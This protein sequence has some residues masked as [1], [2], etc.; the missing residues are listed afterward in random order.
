MWLNRD[1]PTALSANEKVGV[2]RQ[3][4]ELNP[5][6]AV[7]FTGGEPFSKFAEL[8][9]LAATA[10]ALGLVS[11]VNTNGSLIDRYK[12]AAVAADGP[13]HTVVSLDSIQPDLHDR[14]RGVEGAFERATQAITLLAQAFRGRPE[15]RIFVSS[16]LFEGNLA[17]VPALIALA[18]FL[19]AHGITFQLLDHTFDRRGK[20]DKFFE[21]GWFKDTR[22]A[23]RCLVDYASRIGPDAFVLTQSEGLIAMAARVH[24]SGSGTRPVC[25]AHRRNLVVNSSGDVLLCAYMRQLNEGRSLGNVRLQRLA[26]M[27]SGEEATR[28]RP[29]MASCLKPCGLLNCNRAQETP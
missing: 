10:S 27:I 19:G 13:T 26:E 21:S 22:A 12:A 28:V 8:R 7:V 1:V 14:V 5:E 6:G 29:I 23:A 3:F 17:E 9:E 24:P 16:V 18:R 11:V 25:D 20:R 15:K 4:A 2:I